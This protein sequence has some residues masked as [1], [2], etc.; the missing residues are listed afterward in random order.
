MDWYRSGD[1]MTKAWLVGGIALL[2]ALLVT[3]VI[4]A[5]LEREEPLPEGTPEATVQRFLKAVEAEE[6][7]LAHTLFGDD[8][9][10][11]CRVETLF[12]GTPREE[13]RLEDNRITLER[14]MI[15]DGI[16][17]VTVR[18]TEFLG[19][20]FFGSS[21]S[22]FE[23]RFTLRQ[24]EGQWR[25]SEY[26]WPFSQCRSFEPVRPRS[27]QDTDPPVPES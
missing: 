7:K 15:V 2:G 14:T 21:E 5:L 17:V 16:A 10:E 9:K 25:F 27:P 1:Q 4:V 8:L 6:F 12:S 3:S 22:S 19:G 18:V 11:H 23:R 24:E 13:S 26:P 20:G